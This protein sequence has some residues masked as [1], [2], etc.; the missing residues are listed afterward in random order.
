MTAKALQDVRFAKAKDVMEKKFICIDGSA[1]VAEAVQKMREE[2]VA[3][4][5]VNRRTPDDAWGIV[6]Q[7]DV[8][9]KVVDPG[10]SAA[11]VF[12]YEIMSKPLVT[13]APGLALKYC[14]RLFRMTGI[15]R[16]PVFDGKQ[17]IGLLS[18]TEI[19][20]AIE[21]ESHLI[22][23]VMDDDEESDLIAHVMDDD[24]DNEIEDEDDSD[25]VANVMD[26]DELIA[27]V[28]DE[29]PV[30]QGFPDSDE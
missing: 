11:D 30:R 16:A 19:F 9:S 2:S 17:I 8:V 28:R 12:V 14:A 27:T 15:R 18:N 24:A 13:V 6:T 1:T 3:A 20:N 29:E 10:K 7:K 4:L 22:A 23:H 21:D 25:L 5:V 26:E